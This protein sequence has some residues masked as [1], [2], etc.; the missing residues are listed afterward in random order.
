VCGRVALRR[1]T[2]R[3]GCGTN[4]GIRCAGT[5]FPVCQLPGGFRVRRENPRRELA[6][7]RTGVLL[8]RG[9]LGTW[10]PAHRRSTLFVRAGGGRS[11]I[12][13]LISLSQLKSFAR[14]RPQLPAASF[15]LHS[16][17][18]IPGARKKSPA[19]PALTAHMS[20]CLTR[21]R[22]AT[23]PAGTDAKWTR[24]R[25]RR[26]RRNPGRSEAPELDT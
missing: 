5:N 2:R 9:N 16:P 24:P 18:T 6:P 11:E 13:P 15:V 21:R 4:S 22:R 10:E 7:T 12:R 1:D 20:P 17:S 25:H 3:R 26:A 23:E 19:R 8:N 14:T